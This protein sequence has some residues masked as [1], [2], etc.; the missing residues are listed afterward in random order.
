MKHKQS[1]A[2]ISGGDV[3]LPAGLF[4]NEQEIFLCCGYDGTETIDD[5]GRIYVPANWLATEF[6]DHEEKIKTL[7]QQIRIGGRP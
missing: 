2:I 7:I 1:T 4:G 5:G 3:F 6:P